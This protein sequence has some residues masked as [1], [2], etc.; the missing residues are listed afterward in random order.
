M[1]QTVEDSV[2]NAYEEKAAENGQLTGEHLKQIIEENQ[3]TMRDMI[4]EKLTKL[5]SEIQQRLIGAST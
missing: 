4:N 2:K 5:K 3:K 1:A